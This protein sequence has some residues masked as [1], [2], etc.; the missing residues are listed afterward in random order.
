MDAIAR[1]RADG[2]LV[3]GDPFNGGDRLVKALR[4]RLGART[5]IMGGFLFFP[6]DVLERI[7]RAGHG[8]YMTTLD[9]PRGVLPLTAEGRRF[10]RDIG[11]PATQY[12]GV[13][14]AAQ[15]A[16]LVLDAIARSDGTRASVLKEL[17]AS[18]VRDG[19]LGS[20]HFDRNG[21]ISA[22]AIPVLRITGTT[23]PG[24][25]LPKAFQGAVLDQLVKVPA[26]LVE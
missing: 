1:S 25:D 8:M 10:A 20:F 24:T 3:G 7:G 23:T 16:E 26:S 2:V 11:D 14:E 5:T 6:A 19:I 18:E 12:I 13:L 4:A 17:Q 22:A 15:A 9:L 21:D